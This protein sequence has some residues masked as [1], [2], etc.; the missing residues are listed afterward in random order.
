MLP[1]HD[2]LTRCPF[3]LSRLVNVSETG[4]VVYQAEKQACRAF[5]DP[6]GDGTRAGVKRN[7]QILSALDFLAEFTQHIPPKGSHLMRHM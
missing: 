5:P 2:G 4:Q 3:S 6:K 1:T 7:F